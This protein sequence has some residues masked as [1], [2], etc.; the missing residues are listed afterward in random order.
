M[1]IKEQLEHKINQ[2]TKPIGSLGQLER[3]A[4]Q[5]GLIQNT[6][7]PEISKPHI[8]VFAADHGIAEHGKV[9]PYPQ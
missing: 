6:L 3:I 4:L 7:N 8:I 1:S 9:N 5:V 2:K